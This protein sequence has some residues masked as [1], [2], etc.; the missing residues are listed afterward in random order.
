[1]SM[2]LDRDSLQEMYLSDLQDY[3]SCV[4]ARACSRVSNTS[5]QLFL[6]SQCSFEYHPKEV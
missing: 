3:D 6:K 2:G 1:M 4:V 5:L